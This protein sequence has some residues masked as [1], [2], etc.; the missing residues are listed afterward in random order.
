M[1]VEY[2]GARGNISNG[3]STRGY[4]EG[5]AHSSDRAGVLKV[6]TVYVPNSVSQVTPSVGDWTW[7]VEGSTDGPFKL[8]VGWTVSSGYGVA[9]SWDVS[10]NVWAID[11]MIIDGA[12]LTDPFQVRPVLTSADSGSNPATG[13]VTPTEP[14]GMVVAHFNVRYTRSS[15]SRTLGTVSGLTMGSLAA[16]QTTSAG[17]VHRR[18]RLDNA[19][20]GVTRGPYTASG[21]STYA[22]GWRAVAYVLREPRPWVPQN[23]QFHTLA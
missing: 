8:W 9:W 5:A 7:L 2:L 6:A 4:D 1:P 17:H 15:S 16:S 3:S 11:Y 13:A 21:T 19:P 20:V 18:G 22:D 12:D 10:V 23:K 14:G